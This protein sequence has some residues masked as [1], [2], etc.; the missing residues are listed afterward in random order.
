MASGFRISLLYRK[1]NTHTHTCSGTIR[2][3]LVLLLR[4][5]TEP[6]E[7]CSARKSGKLITFYL[8]IGTTEKQPVSNLTLTEGH[9]VFE[10][11]FIAT[12]WITLSHTHTH[13]GGPTMY[14]DLP[15]RSDSLG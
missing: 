11:F 12:N 1:M 15:P 3:G 6:V 10:N 8:K 13:S 9:V 5:L 2:L 14:P 4:G 7:G